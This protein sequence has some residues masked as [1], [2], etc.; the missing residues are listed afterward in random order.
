MR[1][2]APCTMRWLMARPRPVPWSFVVKKGRK[3][4]SSTFCEMP[5]PLSATMS[6]TN[7]SSAAGRPSRVPAAEA[8]ARGDG[9]LAAALHGLGGVADEVHQ[10]LAELLG[11]D[12]DARQGGRRAVTSTLML[13]A[14]GLAERICSGAPHDGVDVGRAPPRRP[15][16]GARDRGRSRRRGRGGRPLRG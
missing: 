8:H 12:G 3:R 1:P 10:H 14:A 7:G 13:L 15:R 11:V 16:S 4:F 9:D 6:S 2:P 5:G